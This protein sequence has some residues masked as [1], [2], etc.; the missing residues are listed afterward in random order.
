MININISNNIIDNNT[1]RQSISKDHGVVAMVSL[2]ANTAT[3]SSKTSI[4]N[5][6]GYFKEQPLFVKIRPKED[7]K[8]YLFYS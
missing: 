7:K 8:I 5:K 1:G 3:K 6:S 2:T 4:G